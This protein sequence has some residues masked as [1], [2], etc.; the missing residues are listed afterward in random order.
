MVGREP[1]AVAEV[2]APV[3]RLR[4]PEVM[5]GSRSRSQSYQTPRRRQCRWYK[6]TIG[7]FLCFCGMFPVKA[8]LYWSC[9]SWTR[10]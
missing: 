8:L 10:H 1:L 6:H 2:A 3:K 4:N 9:G 7:L 5:R